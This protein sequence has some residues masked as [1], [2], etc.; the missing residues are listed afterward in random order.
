MET[1]RV[2]RPVVE[3][4]HPLDEEQVPDPDPHLSENCI[5]VQIR[6]KVKAGPECFKLRSVILF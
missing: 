3:D 6:I 2:C 4:S 1:R 5:R